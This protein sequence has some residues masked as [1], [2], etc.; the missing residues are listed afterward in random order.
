MKLL[1]LW[2]TRKDSEDLR[3][4]DKAQKE[5]DAQDKAEKAVKDKNEEDIRDLLS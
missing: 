3:T 5:S 4:N 2:V 1:L